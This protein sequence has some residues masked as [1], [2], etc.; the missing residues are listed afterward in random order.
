MLNLLS[1][2]YTHVMLSGYT[3]ELIQKIV[4]IVKVSLIT[5]MTKL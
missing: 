5:V 4:D 3:E 1:G 2:R